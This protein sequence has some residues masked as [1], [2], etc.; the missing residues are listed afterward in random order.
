MSKMCY[1]GAEKADR[2]H[3]AS[4]VIIAKENLLCFNHDENKFLNCI[5]T[6]DEK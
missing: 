5:V 1:V 6:G 3:K 2:R 4:W